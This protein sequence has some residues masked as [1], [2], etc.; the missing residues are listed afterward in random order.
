[1]T[2]PFYS[3][4]SRI[5]AVWIINVSSLQYSCIQR[6]SIVYKKADKR[7]SGSPTKGS[8]QKL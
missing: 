2:F 3:D 7:E 1:M 5:D 8:V 6:V 4:R